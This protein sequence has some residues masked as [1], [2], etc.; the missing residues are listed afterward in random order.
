MAVKFQPFDEAFLQDPYPT[1]EE[2]RQ[3]APIYRVRF[4][5]HIFNPRRD[6]CQP[7]I[8]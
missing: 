6:V 1:Y 8:W 4:G 5:Y 7:S 2:L 3:Q